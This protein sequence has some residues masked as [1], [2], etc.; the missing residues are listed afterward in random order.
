MDIT[1]MTTEASAS[2]QTSAR[3]NYLWTTGD[4]PAISHL[5]KIDAGT[6]GEVHK[7]LSI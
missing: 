7:V 6:Y 4:D 1:G 5:H 2:V 3:F